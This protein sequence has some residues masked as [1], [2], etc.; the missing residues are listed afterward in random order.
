MSIHITLHLH[1]N[2]I[3]I[4]VHVQNKMSTFFNWSYS[5]AKGCLG[6]IHVSQ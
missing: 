6:K 5:T 3:N 2:N 4:G 1:F